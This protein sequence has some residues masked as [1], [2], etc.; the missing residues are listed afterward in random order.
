MTNFPKILVA[1]PTYDG[2][3]YCQNKFFDA[4]KSLDYPNLDILIVDNSEKEDYFNE[5]KKIDKLIVL[6]D[7]SREKNKMLRLVGSRNKIIDYAIKNNYDYI[8]MVDSD[9]ILPKSIISELLSCNKSIVSGLYSNYFVVDGKTK[10]LPVAW[11]SLTE[12]EFEEIKQKVNLPDFIRSN[13]DLRAHL[14][15][16]EA[17]SNKLIEVIIPSAGCML[18]SREVFTKVRYGI[19]DT[20]SQGEVKT[21]DDIYFSLEARKLGFKS[22]CNTKIK[23]EHLVKGKFEIDSQGIHHHPIYK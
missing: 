5:L 4:V 23:C 14:T 13:Q 16:E 21:T 2:M 20:A 11:T 3:R 17:D 18:I 22:Y 1:S 9:V 19:L 6:R 8:L 10:W 12:E 15:E 7:N